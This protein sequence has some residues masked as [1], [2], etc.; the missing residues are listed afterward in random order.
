[1]PRARKTKEA[2][3]VAPT[4]ATLSKAAERFAGQHPPSV[5]LST[6]HAA[7][8]DLPQDSGIARSAIDHPESEA[9][10]ANP[11]EIVQGPFGDSIKINRPAEELVHKCPLFP[12]GHL[13][14][15]VSGASGCGKSTVVCSILPNIAK[16]SQVIMCSGIIGNPVYDTIQDWCQANKILYT[17]FDE[18]DEAMCGI[19]QLN[20]MKEP[21]TYGVII[22]DDFSPS[23]KASDDAYNVLANDVSRKLRNYGY[24]SIYVMQST[25]SFQTIQ[26]CNA[27]IRIVFEMGDKHALDSLANDMVASGL[28]EEPDDFK[29]L[30]RCVLAEKHS[31]M[32]II[33]G[34]GAQRKVYL[35]TPSSGRLTEV[36]TS[37][38]GVPS[39]PHYEKSAGWAPN[40]IAQ[41][42]GSR[43]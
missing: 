4:F 23:K 29:R 15:L 41:S 25:T 35:S 17:L 10:R 38:N 39:L 21:G 14:I 11:V 30:F 27:N 18:P 7:V 32:M 9:S 43:D 36:M 33:S 24:H 5:Y 40:G 12:K 34:A 20:A 42:E 2:K 6:S 3:T 16:L 28:F 37:F 13:S 19:E 26:R 8:K 22:F 1:M 31:F